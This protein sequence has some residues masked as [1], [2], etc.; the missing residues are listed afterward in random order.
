MF[1]KTPVK[2]R[3]VCFKNTMFVEA[4][5][6]SVPFD[7]SRCCYARKFAGLMQWFS[8]QMGFGNSQIRC[9]IKQIKSIIFYKINKFDKSNTHERRVLQFANI[10]CSDYK[11]VEIELKNYMR[12]EYKNSTKVR[13][14]CFLKGQKLIPVGTITFH[15]IPQLL[16]LQVQFIEQQLSGKV[17]YIKLKML[18][19]SL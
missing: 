12:V 15:P 4:Q 18:W 19:P 9:L 14:L 7:R 16:D 5:T 17:M 13:F 1:L 3:R 2:E 8:M 11:F 6:F 10:W